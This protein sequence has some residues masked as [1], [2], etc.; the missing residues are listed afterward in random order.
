ME[1]FVYNTG[2]ISIGTGQSTVSGIGTAWSGRDRAGSQI[3]AYVGGAPVRIGT[4][5]EVEPRGAYDNLTLPLVTA[6]DGAPIE[7]AEYELVDGAAIANGATQAAIYARFAAHL[8]QNMG[9]VGNTTDQIDWALVPNN[10]LFIDAATRAIHQWRNGVL[11]TVHVVGTAFNPRGAWDDATV[12]ARSDLVTHEGAAYVSN[13]DDNEDNEPDGADEYWTPIGIVGA[14][15][16]SPQL[17]VM[18]SVLEW[19]YP[20][21]IDWTLLVDLSPITAEAVAA[22]EDA[23]EAASAAEGFA[24]AASGSADAA[25]DSALAAGGFADAASG[26]ASAASGFADAAEGHADTASLAADAAGASASTAGGHASDASDSA[27]AAASSALTAEGHASAAS[28]SASTA[29]A[30]AIEATDAATAAEGHAEAA[31]L[32][33]GAAAGSAIEAEGFAQDASGSASTATDASSA[34]N[35]FAGAAE[36]HADAA[37]L[38]AGAA[39]ASAL[40]A[41]G[42]ASDA[43]DSA[44]EA[45][46]SASAASGFASQAEAAALE[47]LEAAETATEAAVS[48][49]ITCVLSDAGEALATGGWVLVADH[50]IAASRQRLRLDLLYG[51]DEGE[52][53]LYFELDGEPISGPHYVSAASSPVIDPEG[54]P[55]LEVGSRL[56]VY[57]VGAL[58]GPFAIAIQ[59]DGRPA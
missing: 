24:E 54:G 46:G 7:D 48:G 59:M 27:D 4:V 33:A 30:K 3:W 36:G 38:S 19:K 49:A 50:H 39:A 53:I 22:A 35:G 41:G 29:A 45:A 57:N 15:G 9:L 44:D 6:Y 16:Q 14:D 25:A 20:S 26:S 17:R 51:P 43:S 10:S 11:E 32:S 47:A 34:A 52:A 18:G 31:D 13:Q 21:E 12:Y 8:E 58:E 42:H 1:R 37:A 55:V 40:T 23:A 56:T 28:G 2:N 5:A